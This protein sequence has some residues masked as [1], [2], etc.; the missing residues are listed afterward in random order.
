MILLFYLLVSV[1]IVWIVISIDVYKG[2]SKVSTIFDYPYKHSG[3]LV[4]I[5]VPARNEEKAIY[6]SIRSQLTQEYNHIEWIV[7]NDRSTDKTAE[8]IHKLTQHDE[9]VKAIHLTS[10]NKGW[11]GKNHALYKG[12]LQSKGEILLFTDAD[13][14][15]LD[16]T[17]LSRAVS[18]LQT[19]H[20]DHLTL[21][22]QLKAQ[23]YWLKSFIAFFLFGF[24]F[25]KRP[26]KANDPTSKI[27]MGIGAFNII[28]RS[29]Y[30][31]IGTHEAIKE[32]PD[33]DL[34][35]GMKIKQHDKKQ[36]F[37]T[38]LPALEV[39]WYGSI[40]EAFRG[41]EKNTFAGLHYSYLMVFISILGVF[42][43]TVLPFITI[44]IPKNPVQLISLAILLLIFQTY[45]TVIKHM[46][47][48]SL[49]HFVTL[50]I[51]ALLFI[52]SIIRATFLTIKRGGI[53]W[54]GTVYSFKELKQKKK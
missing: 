31:Q 16:S 54:R 21:A 8:K 12:Y 34:Q 1:L 17:I 46:T 3:P 25:Y 24:S 23:S 11:L 44:F 36:K 14:M 26:W 18:C 6:Q 13:V 32:V 20:I 5:I 15:F 43:S 4:S 30:Q 9:R 49:I 50:P 28:T 22:P 51:T 47:M 2:L 19:Q 48:T 41:L 53:E 42:C 27:G 45:R 39:E 33:D 35:L 29:A 37:L 52:Y 10:I 7:V 40:K 38:A